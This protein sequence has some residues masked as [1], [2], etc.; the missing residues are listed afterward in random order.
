MASK[1]LNIQVL[2]YKKA[3]ESG[4]VQETYQ[5]LVG[6]IQSLLHISEHS[7]QSFRDS[8]ITHFRCFSSKLS[9]LLHICNL[10]GCFVLWI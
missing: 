4:E 2:A 9:P 8:P 3:L 6:I 7:D 10:L 1:S 5:R